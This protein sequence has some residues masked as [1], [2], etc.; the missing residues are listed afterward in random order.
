[1]YNQI[2]NELKMHQ[3]ASLAH[4]NFCVTLPGILTSFTICP[5][6]NSCIIAVKMLSSALR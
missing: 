4:L 6:F 5:L 2:S 1:M 3:K